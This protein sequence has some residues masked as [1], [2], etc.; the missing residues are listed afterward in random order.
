MIGFPIGKVGLSM[1]LGKVTGPGAPT[2]LAEGL[3]VSV[4]KDIVTPHGENA[5]LAAPTIMLSTCSKT[6]FA[7]FKPVAMET[8]SIATCTHP[9]TL[10]APTVK[11]GP[12]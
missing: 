2:V 3:P 5:H 7:G 12:I 1:C 10:G 8:Q 6:V 9:L 11:V 4:A